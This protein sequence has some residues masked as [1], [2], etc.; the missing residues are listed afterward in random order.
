[1]LL[2][3]TAALVFTSLAQVPTFLGPGGFE[4][5]LALQPGEV[6]V[7]YT[8]EGA[9]VV[10]F[11]RPDP[12]VTI[13]FGERGRRSDT[14]LYLP[15]HRLDEAALTGATLV[16]AQG[17][18]QTEGAFG[19][20][21]AFAPDTYVHY[22][23]P[24]IDRPLPGWT[25]SFW[26][27]PR[28]TAFG[29]ALLVTDTGCDLFLQLDGRVRV[30]L[31]GAPS[32]QSAP[33]LSADRWSFVSVSVDPLQLG[34]LRVLVD[35]QAN[36]I[37]LPSATLLPMP[38]ELK[39]GDL[40]RGGRGPTLA[41]DELALE[42]RV[43][44]SAR[45]AERRA[46]PLA[47]GPHG[48]ELRTTLGLR[49]V[50][51]IAGVLSTRLVTTPAE[52]AQGQLEGALVVGNELRWAPARWRRIF[53]E[54][55]PAPR[56]THP[57]LS[58]G[59]GRTFVFGGETRD[60]TLWP[61]V[62]TSDTWLFDSASQQW[63]FVPTS[64]APTPRCHMPAAYSPDHDLVL[65]HGGWR[66]D[67]SPGNLFSDTWAFHVGQRR[68][69]QVSA[70]GTG[71]GT[72][73]DHAL[74]YLPAR[75]Q[76]LLLR[77]GSGWLFD[78]V[79]YHWTPLGR[80]NAVDEA[81][82]PTTYDLGASTAFTLDP[83]TGLVILYGG[84][85]GGPPMTFT[86]TTA[87]YDVNTHTFTVLAPA[88]RPPARVRGGFGFDERH[89]Q[90]VLFG[91]VQDQFSTRRDDLWIFD[92]P[93]RTWT[94][95]LA[96]N[97]PGRRGGYYGMSYDET[98]GSFLLACG[99]EAFDVW[100]DDTWELTLAPA[101]LGTALY[102]LDLGPTG[103]SGSWFADVDEPG[104]A[105]VRL[106]VRRSDNLRSWSGWRPAGGPIGNARYLQVAV[107]LKPGSAGEAPSVRAFGFR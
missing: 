102:T 34:L 106:F 104:D 53:T 73:S 10:P 62:N 54:D 85:Y 46:P 41:L 71:P 15:A 99:R 44:S 25:L 17:L 43:D 49:T 57:V 67:Y 76:F 77:G 18:G 96:S 37:V 3:S 50:D 6:L 27:R 42:A 78:P 8:W 14:L 40:G 13:P 101:R 36:G 39:L 91:G 60:T 58:L 80:A 98:R 65:V 20:A 88:V 5:E 74:V 64:S 107:G 63:N 24:R 45:A 59:G 68:W 19:S 9:G 26:V 87:L 90:V 31:P 48:L 38:S 92:P 72:V 75:R 95:I 21:L 1:M 35:D 33:V 4:Y 11:L 12:V 51:P 32:L 52:L 82:Q 89:G 103:S 86:D 66:N 7:D 69:E 83:R 47:P 16:L 97:A 56:T 23:L 29:R 105:R 2:A 94:E 61:M 70:T 93:T 100:L 30:T 28:A 84:S 79:A 55:A 22:R 81:G